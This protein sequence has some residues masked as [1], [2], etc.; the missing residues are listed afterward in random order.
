M[1]DL[2]RR[3]STERC[4]DLFT[5]TPRVSIDF[6]VER[7]GYWRVYSK[8][9]RLSLNTLNLP[10]TRELRLSEDTAIHFTPKSTNSEVVHQQG[11]IF[12]LTDLFLVCERIAPE[13]RK[14]CQPETADMWLCY[15]PLAAKH[16][17]IAPLE[18]SQW[19]FSTKEISKIIN[20]LPQTMV[21]R[22][23]YWKGKLCDFTLIQ[24]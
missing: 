9:V 2:E 5:M 8:T 11:H 3:L 23:Q 18:G 17:K 20:C 16:L 10:Y 4:Q 22:S 15:P 24:E 1:I 7:D 21:Q 6:T 19:R 12:L 14:Q 13:D